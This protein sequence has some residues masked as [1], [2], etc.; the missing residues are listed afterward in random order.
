MI[1]LSAM[2][3][4]TE[5]PALHR[6]LE[7]CRAE[8][9]NVIAVRL[10]KALATGELTEGSSPNAMAAYYMAI[11]QGISVQARDGASRTTLM[12]IAAQAMA[13]WPE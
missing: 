8:D 11:M 12:A 1:V 13:A 3:G 9:R 10:K 6:E 2:S 7:R 5:S 4:F